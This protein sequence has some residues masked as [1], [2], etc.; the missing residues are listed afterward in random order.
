[1][2]LLLHLL[3]LIPVCVSAHRNP[4]PLLMDEDPKPAIIPNP[5][6]I[7]TEETPFE[8]PAFRLPKPVA[9]HPPKISPSSIPNPSP[10]IS[11]TKSPETGFPNYGSYLYSIPGYSAFQPVSFSSVVQPHSGPVIAEATKPDFLPFSPDTAKEPVGEDRLVINEDVKPNVNPSKQQ[12][13]EEHF[14]PEIVQAAQNP[15]THSKT[16]T[17]S[18]MNITSL[19]QGSGATVTIPNQV[20]KNSRKKP[21][22][23][24]LKTSI[25]ISKIDIKCVTSSVDTFQN[26]TKKPVFNPAFQKEIV[27]KPKVE[28]QSNIV[29]KTATKQTDVKE[30]PAVVSP[31]NS[32]NTL[33]NA[34]EAIN[35]IDNQFRASEIKT[36]VS[37]QPT[38][39]KKPPSPNLQPAPAVVQ[40]PMFNPLNLEKPNFP[41][42]PPEGGFNEQKNQIL[43]VQNK[44]ITNPKMTLQNPKNPQVL[45]KRTNFDSK[46]LQAP[47]RLSNQ[48]RKVKEVVADKATSSKVVALKRLHQDNGDENDFENLI[49]ENQIYGTKIVVKE[50]S[51]GVKQEQDLKAKGKDKQTQSD[52]KNV[53]L[54][55]SY[56]YVSNVQFPANLIMI[57]PNSKTCQTTDS[58]KTKVSP[59][60]NQTTEVTTTV[61]NNNDTTTTIKNCKPQIVTTNDIHILKTSNVLQTLSNNNN[62][63]PEIVAANPKILMNPHV[64]YQAIPDAN[65]KNQIRREIPSVMEAKKDL[66][67]LIEIKGTEKK[68]FFACQYKVDSKLATKLVITNLKPKLATKVEVVSTLDIYARRKRLRRLK[69]LSNNNKDIPKL[70]IRKLQ[71][72]AMISTKNIITPDKMKAEIFK[73]FANTKS[74]FNT[75]NNESDSDYG[76]EELSEYNSIIEEYGPSDLKTKVE[77]FAGL[78]LATHDSYRGKHS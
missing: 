23:F 49:T 29:I 28:I 47:S 64:T 34:A 35:K 3:N 77:F 18:K 69:Y 75:Y 20:N 65:N 48:S 76:E 43:Y 7:K 74:K 22:R 42:K 21:E 72:K 9:S 70:E 6:S 27:E 30:K 53:V 41:L 32:I 51:Q 40:R 8:K 60:E 2:L 55:P 13:F 68:I 67:K 26:S 78:R 38:T 19:T 50:K 45:L 12:D 31:N 58:Y 56:V 1:M 17:E 24:S 52:T 15:E 57:K 62:M 16:Q 36:D 10:S 5:E 59:S 37:S 14:T 33:I 71:D 66:P 4:T 46:N 44:N 39:V 73:E 25:P 63:K 61:T 11:T 54:Q